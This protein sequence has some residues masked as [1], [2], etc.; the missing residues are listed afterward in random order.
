MA[1]VDWMIKGPQ[2]STCN[3]DYGCPC[4]FN[5]LPTR[6]NCR[7]SIAMR[8]DEGHFGETDL[9]GVKFASCIAWPGAIHEGHGE[10]QAVVDEAASEDQRNAVLTILA[11]KETAPGAT[12]FNLF[13]NVL[14]TV[15]KPLFLPI[16]FEMDLDQATGSF[17]VDGFAEARVEPIR[18]PVTGAV[19]RARVTIPDGFEYHEAEY[20]SSSTRASGVIAH[21]W[22]GRHAHLAIM[23]M[24]QNGVVHA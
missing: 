15:H 3:C 12:I 14:E 6:G 4:Q 13:T 23:H 18:N 22:S 8:I 9:S 20:A 16:R 10:V 21:E 2:I 7:A 19:H 17:A 1:Y 11:G 5:A 24:T